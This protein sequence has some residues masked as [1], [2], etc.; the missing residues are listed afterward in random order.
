MVKKATELRPGDVVEVEWGL[1][2]YNA[3]VVQV[4]ESAGRTHVV[5]EVPVLDSRGAVVSLST[6]SVPVEVLQPA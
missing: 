6:A 3:T 1:A 4:Y 2:T 5:L